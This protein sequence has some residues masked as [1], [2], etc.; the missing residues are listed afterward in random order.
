MFTENVCPK[1][2]EIWWL[3]DDVTT[4]D[5]NDDTTSVI[6]KQTMEGEETGNPEAKKKGLRAVYQANCKGERRRFENAM[7]RDD[8]KCDLF[9][10]AKRMV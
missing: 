7:R 5:A 2:Q 4:G 8:E 10:I 6:K 1:K 3:N 9:K